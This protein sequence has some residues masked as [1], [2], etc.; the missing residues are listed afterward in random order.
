MVRV[1]VGGGGRGGGGTGWGGECVCSPSTA[2]LPYEESQLNRDSD[3]RSVFDVS[4]GNLYEFYLHRMIVFTVCLCTESQTPNSF[5][6]SFFTEEDSV[7]F[8]LCW[9]VFT[10]MTSQSGSENAFTC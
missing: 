10:L 6:S 7:L 9:S 2:F 8:F 5:L 1:G 4:E 3:F